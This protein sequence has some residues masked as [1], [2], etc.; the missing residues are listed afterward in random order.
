MSLEE[1]A[2]EEEYKGKEE[3]AINKKGLLAGGERVAAKSKLLV[4]S[5]ASYLDALTDEEGLGG[6]AG[7]AA[8]VAGKLGEVQT[9]RDGV[10][11][12]AHS[13]VVSVPAGSALMDT[14]VE[15]SEPLLEPP[16]VENIGLRAGT[17]LAIRR[18]GGVLFGDVDGVEGEVADDGDMTSTQH[19][20][21]IGED[22]VDISIGGLGRLLV[23]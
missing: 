11:R 2:G 21:R 23:E 18:E 10:G 7:G 19:R 6:T 4:L 8:P 14:H 13:L 20:I 5:E 15:D 1:I 12:V 3:T 17:V 9:R 16:F 22:E